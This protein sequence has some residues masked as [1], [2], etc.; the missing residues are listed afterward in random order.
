MSNWRN[1]T[2]LWFARWYVKNAR[3]TLHAVATDL[4]KCRELEPESAD[5]INTALDEGIYPAISTLN[6]LFDNLEQKKEDIK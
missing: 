5:T 6:K 3:K 2:S 4:Y 1:K